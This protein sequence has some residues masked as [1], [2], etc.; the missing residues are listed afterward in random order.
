MTTEQLLYLSKPPH[1]LGGKDPI[2]EKALK[3]Y[4]DNNED[5]LKLLCHDHYRKI[6]SFVFKFHSFDPTYYNPG[7]SGLS[8]AAKD[9]IRK[10]FKEEIKSAMSLTVTGIRLPDD[11][12]ELFG[13]F[14]SLNF[15]YCEPSKYS[16][17]VV[18]SDYESE[19]R[20]S[21]QEIKNMPFLQI[22]TRN[23]LW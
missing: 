4:N 8:Q 21:L 13:E 6:A 1:R 12:M 9:E 3:I 10:I 18:V 19:S 11:S 15:K 20:T 14:A 7:P 23:S 5:K 16:F 22:Q 17:R 2:W